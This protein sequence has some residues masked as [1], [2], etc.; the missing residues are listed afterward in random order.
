VH[1]RHFPGALA[2]LK[3]KR[4]PSQCLSPSKTHRLHPYNK[5][6]IGKNLKK[7]DFVSCKEGCGLEAAA[8]CVVAAVVP[9]CQ[10]CIAVDPAEILYC[11]CPLA[12]PHTSDAFCM[13]TGGAPSCWSCPLLSCR[14]GWGAAGL[15]L[16]SS[17]RFLLCSVLYLSLSS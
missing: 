6:N 9:T 2:L 10:H 4:S 13:H 11:S 16:A 7:R 14:C 5:L 15:L 17:L 8:L 1:L 12:S 3:N